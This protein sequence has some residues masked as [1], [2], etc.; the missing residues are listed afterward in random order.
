MRRESILPMT[1]IMRNSAGYVAMLMAAVIC[2][3]LLVER[4]ARLAAGAPA[5]IQATM[6]SAP[7]A[8]SSQPLVHVLIALVA[9]VVA[10]RLLG[11]AFRRLRQPPVIGEVAA[12]IILGPS[13]LGNAWP[14]AAHFIM[15]ESATPLVGVL[16]QIGVVLYMFLVGL[17]LDTGVFKRQTK[18]SLAV[19]HASIVLPFTLGGVL[20]LWLY[21]RFATAD[22]PFVAFAAFC[23]VSMS[24]T[25]FPVLTRIIGDLGLKATRLG[26]LAIACAAI[27]DLT[28]WC[29][30]AFVVALVRAEPGSALVTLAL[31][32]GYL[33]LMLIVVRPLLTRLSRASE[34]R[35]LSQNGFALVCAALLCSA[36]LTEAIGIHALFGAFL[37]GALIPHESRLAAQIQAKL[38]ELVPVLLLPAFFAFTGLRT[39]LTLIQSGH[40]WL[41]CLAVIAV[42]SLGKFGGSAAAA[43]VAGIGWRESLALGALMNTRGL[44]ELI[45]L[46]I[47]LDLGVLT[48]KLFAI[49][50]VMALVTTTATAPLL[51]WL[52]RPAAR[53]A[54]PDGELARS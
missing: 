45:I 42:A 15:P 8:P 3:W 35:D 30:L 49:F 21:P 14:Q 53:A 52:Y 29:L 50:V 20:A 16:A 10:A 12:G 5:T 48:P 23:G 1:T 32:G 7:H 2:F 9:V 41:W 19:S 37:L 24:V 38:G 4:G 40:D 47:A 39:E 11:L 17:E 54:I 34:T 6:P 26:N 28:A 36:A 43:R 31:T 27:D 33:A 51:H 25:A 46:N 13:L 22:V 44:M 18:S